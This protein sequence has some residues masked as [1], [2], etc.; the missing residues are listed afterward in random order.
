MKILVIQDNKEILEMWA[1]WCSEAGCDPE[2][3]LGQ[4]SG[5]FAAKLRLLLANNEFEGTLMDF[6]FLGSDNADRLLGLL[7]PKEQEKMGLKLLCSNADPA[8][9]G[10]FA[11]RDDVVYVGPPERENI[12]ESLENHFVA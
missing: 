2:P 5:D 1:I 6:L 11:V 3:I 4:T 7:S 10:D 12:L 8:T 9:L